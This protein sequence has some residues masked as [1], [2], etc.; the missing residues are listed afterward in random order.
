MSSRTSRRSARK[1]LQFDN[2]FSSSPRNGRRGLHLRSRLG[3]PEGTLGRVFNKR[4]RRTLLGLGVVMVCVFLFYLFVFALPSPVASVLPL[5]GSVMC[6]NRVDLEVS[7]KNEVDIK[8]ISLHFDGKNVLP[9]SGYDGKFLRGGHDVEDGEHTARLRIRRSGWPKARTIT[10][11][12]TTDTKP[13]PLEAELVRPTKNNEGK[14]GQGDNTG[15]YSIKGKTEP[16]A[17]VT[18]NSETVEVDKKG[19]FDF[20]C[21]GEKGGSIQVL[22]K[23]G[24]GNRSEKWL[25]TEQAPEVK[26]VHVTIWKATSEKSFRE[27]LDLAERTELN[28]LVIDIKNVKGTVIQES[29]VPLAKEIGTGEGL[30]DLDT[31]VDQMRYRSIYPICRLVVFKDS[32]LAQERQ[33]LAVLDKYGGLWGGGEWVDPYSREVWDYNVSVAEEAARAGFQEIQFDYVRFPSDGNVTRC[34]FP[35]KDRRS[36][37]EV[38]SGFLKYARERLAKYNVFVSADLFGLTASEQGEMGIGQSIKSLAENT[39]FICPMVYPSHYASGEYDIKNPEANPHDIV[40]RS[41]EE[42]KKK[43]KGAKAKI[44]PWLQDFTLDITY[45]ADM[46]RRQIQAVE[47]NGIN[48]W[49]LWDPYCTYTESALEPA[50]E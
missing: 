49:L 2:E 44:R 25:V 18:I 50:G 28:S 7:F 1:R 12:F 9:N 19:G 29:E 31:L 10:W 37:Q 32:L 42:F 16:G 11:K 43:V 41:I 27:F 21:E 20:T 4:M 34:K 39:D 24:A 17:E 38:I 15:G 6:R 8:D 45:T 48:E 5:D 47:E 13:P 26:G 14:K 35:N 22:S 36:Q 33:D 23:D 46:V 40:Y 30:A 3:I